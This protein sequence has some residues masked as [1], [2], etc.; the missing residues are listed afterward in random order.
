VPRSRANVLERDACATVVRARA[1]AAR[2]ADAGVRGA[3]HVGDIPVVACSSRWNSCTIGAQGPFD[4]TAK[5]RRGQRAALGP[6]DVHPMAASSTVR[7]AIMFCWRRPHHDGR[8]TDL[9]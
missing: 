8:R 3:S 2:T 5:L 1:K 7:A 6:G 4:A 9:W